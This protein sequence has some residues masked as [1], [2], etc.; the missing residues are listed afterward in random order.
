M[1]D[2]TRPTPHGGIRKPPRKIL[3]E[4]ILPEAPT[5]GIRDKKGEWRPRF[6]NSIEF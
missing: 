2:K 5:F 6:R 1:P 4:S 3:Q